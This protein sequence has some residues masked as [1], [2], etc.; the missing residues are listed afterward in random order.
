VL[1]VLTAGVVKLENYTENLRNLKLNVLD[2]IALFV[3]LN[4]KRMP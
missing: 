1:S 3:S 2:E 4:A